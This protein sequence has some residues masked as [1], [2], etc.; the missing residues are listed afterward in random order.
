MRGKVL[1]GPGMERVV[2]SR[3]RQCACR[4]DDLYLA[5]LRRM[6]EGLFSFAAIAAISLPGEP[7]KV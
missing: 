3:S 4:G 1:G 2:R 6:Q 7:R 5:L